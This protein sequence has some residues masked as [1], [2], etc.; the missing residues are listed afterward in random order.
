MPWEPPSLLPPPAPCCRPPRGR[1]SAL[2][3]LGLAHLAPLRALRVLSLLECEVGDDALRAMCALRGITRLTL[4]YCCHV[5]DAGLAELAALPELRQLAMRGCEGIRCASPRVPA[6]TRCP[7]L[8]LHPSPAEVPRID[9]A[10][11]F[12]AAST[13]RRRA[14]CAA[15]M[16]AFYRCAA[17]RCG[18]QGAGVPRAGRPPWKAGVARPELVPKSAGRRIRRPWAG[19]PAPLPFRAFFSLAAPAGALGAG[20]DLGAASLVELVIALSVE[21]FGEPPLPSETLPTVSPA[22]TPPAWRQV[23]SLTQLNLLRCG[24]SNRQAAALRPLAMLR[25]LCL[26]NSPELTC[27]GIG[28]LVLGCTNLHT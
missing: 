2:T 6:P 17:L 4:D 23:A 27:S 5:T 21:P 3:G 1:C 28:E 10:P 15:L 9:A 8:A 22:C 7:P 12:L 24:V 16:Q 25:V 19:A 18:V 13:R 26:A 14:L 11:G 20:R